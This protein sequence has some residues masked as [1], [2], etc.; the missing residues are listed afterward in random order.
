MYT[1][2]V[3]SGTM[4][5]VYTYEK[6]YIPPTRKRVKRK[7]WTGYKARSSRSGRRAQSSFFRLVRANT[8]PRRPP[9]LLTLTMR[10]IK[11]LKPAWRDFQLF[12]Q[13]WRR[14]NRGIAYIAVAEFQKRGA[15]HF[16]LLVW[17]LTDEEI[18]RERDSRRIAELWGYGF[19]DV[20]TS[21]GSP[22]L[23]TYLAK[24]L[25]KAVHDER[26][27]GSK[28][29]SASRNVVRSVSVKSKEAIAFLEKEIAGEGVD[30]SLL[31]LKE[32]SYTT[33]WL[34]KCDYKVYNFDKSI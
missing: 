18:A 23:A 4:V 32:L 1:K 29:Y 16:H 34:G 20:R 7:D 27:V 22:R 31:P 21:D 30:N 24:Y 26:N 2:I 28:L 9:A 33:K 5:E 3:Q 17:G 11:P 10:D 15:V 13:R 6:D 14:S 25:F 19:V 12:A 8:S